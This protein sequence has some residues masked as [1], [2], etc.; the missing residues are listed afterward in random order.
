M[1]P[2]KTH[3]KI[4]KKLQIHVL[5]F[6]V[7]RCL[8]LCQWPGRQ[9]K[10]QC[11]KLLWYLY[12]LLMY[13]VKKTIPLSVLWFATVAY[14]VLSGS[15]SFVCLQTDKRRTW[16]TICISHI[17]FNTKAVSGQIS[18]NYE[19]HKHKTWAKQNNESAY[20][21]RGDVVSVVMCFQFPFKSA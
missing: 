17:H 18:C 21:N 20:S 4:Y 14:V 6:S 16:P 8:F 3:N 12:G 5:N 1:H 19:T 10:M 15:D 11:Q 13:S 2:K 7:L 9:T